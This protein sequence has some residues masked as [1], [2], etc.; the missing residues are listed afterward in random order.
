MPVIVLFIIFIL[1][2]IC[3]MAAAIAMFCTVYNKVAG[4]IFTVAAIGAVVSIVLAQAHGAFGETKVIHTDNPSQRTYQLVKTFLDDRELYLYGNA[5]DFQYVYLDGDKVESQDVPKDQVTIRY[6]D[7]QPCVVVTQ[8]TSVKRKEWW[9]FYGPDEQKIS[10]QY[11]F[12]LKS[13]DSIK[14]SFENS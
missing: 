2:G 11:E 7:E 13:R 10:T 1:S 5:D 14:F 8:T 3:L 9:I 4:A 12:H 6:T